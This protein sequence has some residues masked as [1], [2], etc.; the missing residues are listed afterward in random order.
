MESTIIL[1]LLAISS[2]LGFLLYVVRGFLDQLP[3]V[4]EAWRR[5]RRAF[6]GDEASGSRST[7]PDGTDPSP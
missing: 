5:V 1:W 4:F 3:E 7:Q 6:Q 2:V